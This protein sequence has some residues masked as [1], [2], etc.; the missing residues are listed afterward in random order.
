MSVILCRMC[1]TIN[2]WLFLPKSKKKYIIF[3][4][5][6]F[7][8]FSCFVWRNCI[9][10]VSM[11]FCWEYSFR[12]Y[13]AH[14][15]SVCKQPWVCS[16][17]FKGECCLCN[18]PAQPPV[19]MDTRQSCLSSTK[20]F[21]HWMACSLRQSI[22]PGSASD[23]SDCSWW[24]LSMSPRYSRHHELGATYLSTQG[25]NQR[26]FPICIWIAMIQETSHSRVQQTAINCA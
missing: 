10:F 6:H 9:L 21:L 18:L 1:C 23:T 7:Y 3:T 24:F 2:D 17:R 14:Q 5:F 26:H 22:S 16:G 15:P 4:M 12:V 8:P 13:W 25:H 20:I 19:M 11:Y